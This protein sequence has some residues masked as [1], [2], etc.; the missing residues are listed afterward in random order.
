MSHPPYP[1][2]QPSPPPGSGSQPPYGGSQPQ[3]GQ[4]PY[5]S[6]SP[7]GN[8]PYGGQPG[9]PHGGQPSKPYG[10]PPGAGAPPPPPGAGGPPAYGGGSMPPQFGGMQPP[11]SPVDALTYGW[12]LFT[13]NVGPFMIITAVM[14]V[15]SAAISFGT[16]LAT[17]GSLFGTGST[18][19]PVTGL[20][21]NYLVHQLISLM[22]S[23]VSGIISWVLGLALVR[24]ALDVVDTGRTDLGAMFT[25]IPWGQAIIAG[26]I[27]MIVTFV[28][29]LMCILPGIV[30]AYLLYYTNMAVL[31]GASGVDGIVASFNFTTKNVGPT[32]LLALLAIV[33]VI[34]SLCTLG[35]ALLIAVPVLCIAAAYTWRVLQGRP[36]VPA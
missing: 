4:P 27:V 8:Q 3:G 25:R 28:G 35:L 20:P 30:A 9:Q 15:I 1:P 16:N 34:L 23:F 24:G 32:L 11:Y 18:V 12:R 10:T 17:T 5:G 7:Y 26:I 13:K 33:I 6:Q 29:T 22:A 2:D 36:V 21:E 14:L 31:D 19:D